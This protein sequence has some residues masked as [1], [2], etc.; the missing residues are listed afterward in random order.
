MGIKTGSRKK[1]KRLVQK[2]KSRF[3]SRK[4]VKSIAEHGCSKVCFNIISL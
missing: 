1:L 4:T 3:K 2:F